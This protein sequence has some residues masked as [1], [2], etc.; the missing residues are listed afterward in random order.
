[1][2]KLLFLFLLTTTLACSKR[3]DVDVKAYP[4]ITTVAE[5]SDYY[6][7]DI[8]TTGAHEFTEITTYFD[9]SWEL[10]YSYD[11]IET[12]R[13]DPLFYSITI[14]G[15]RTVS[16]AEDL[17][18]INKGAI[19]IAERAFDQEQ[20]EIDTVPLPGDEAY[21]A[22]RLS[23]GEPHGM[24]FTMRSGK[25]IYTLIVSGLYS[26]DH[27]LLKDLI[28]PKLHDLRNFELLEE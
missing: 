26:T 24:Y 12:E 16:D 23:E 15:E 4:I 14:E 2:K 13:F 28:L 1:M 17:Y 25:Q 27:S 8:D 19:S 11:F 5:L 20:V 22:L 6:V 3:E 9:G 10:D 18:K 21:Y 7:I